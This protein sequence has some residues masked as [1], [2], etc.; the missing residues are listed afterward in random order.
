MQ[1]GLRELQ[2]ASADGTRVYAVLEWGTD[3]HGIVPILALTSNGVVVPRNDLEMA[4]GDVVVLHFGPTASSSAW[5]TGG[6]VDCRMDGDGEAQVMIA[7]D[8]ILGYDDVP[9]AETR[10]PSLAPDQNNPSVL[11]IC[12]DARRG[13]L[14]VRWFESVGRAASQCEVAGAPRQ[15]LHGAAST[16]ELVVVEVSDRPRRFPELIRRLRTIDVLVPMLVCGRATAEPE[17]RR[18]IMYS[19]ADEVVPIDLGRCRVRRVGARLMARARALRAEGMNG[20]TA[21]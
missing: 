21:A 2:S 3:H 11:V 15:V 4:E 9:T 16:L 14:L 5:S 18:Q 8:A 19:G 7:L 17:L 1:A 20:R 13:A 12:D 10:M 6:V